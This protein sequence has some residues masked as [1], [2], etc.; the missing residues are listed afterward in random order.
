MPEKI[1]HR[2]GVKAPAETI[3]SVASRLTVP[4]PYMLRT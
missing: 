3:W 4:K 1:E 2:I